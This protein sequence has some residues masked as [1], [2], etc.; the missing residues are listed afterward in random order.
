MDINKH[1][2]EIDFKKIFSFL[3]KKRKTILS[4][5]AIALIISSIYAISLTNIYISKA[6][7][8]PAE[9][10][11]PLNNQLGILSSMS[12]LTAQAG[13]SFNQSQGKTEEAIERIKSYDFFINQ[14]M[15]NIKI[16]NLVAVDYWDSNTN[17]VVYNQKIFNAKDKEWS[18]YQDS[19]SKPSKEI[20]FNAY[21]EI[22]RINQDKQSSFVTLI[23]EHPSPI[24]AQYWVDLIVKKIN[25]HMRNIDKDS[26]QKSITY[27]TKAAKNTDISDIKEGISLLLQNEIKK[28]ML[29]ESSDFYVFKYIDS[30][31]IA[32][33]K[34][35][36]YRFIIILIS[37][38]SALLFISIYLIIR[39]IIKSK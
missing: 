22:L 17:T 21:R 2:E 39:L 30:P 33:N 36:P 10:S 37:T 29:I 19:P 25:H 6:I 38:L 31:R 23:I 5:S 3:W 4:F 28:M 14:I 11:R 27:L 20:L 34:S 26:S 35:K 24:I 32:E 1:Q 9:E 13:L 16:E 12:S 15:P 18:F 7:L 8:K